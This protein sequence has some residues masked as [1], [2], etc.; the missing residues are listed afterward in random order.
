MA[1]AIA[2][3]HVRSRLP[4]STFHDAEYKNSGQNHDQ[5]II[6]GGEQAKQFHDVSPP[7]ENTNQNN[8]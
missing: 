3:G 7:T 2:F 8:R 1:M 6:E 5:R 4:I